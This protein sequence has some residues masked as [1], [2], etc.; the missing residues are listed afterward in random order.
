[1][2]LYKYIVAGL[3]G[4]A[5]LSSCTDLEEHPYT[6]IDPNAYYN[7]EAELN[8]G[9]NSVY[10]AYRSLRRWYLYASGRLHRLRTAQPRG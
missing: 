2:K 9:L 1:M 5:A 4:V 7:N 6:F 3:F 10:N 8:S